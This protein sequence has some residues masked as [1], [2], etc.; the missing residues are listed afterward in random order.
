[1]RAG[2]WI[3]GSPANQAAPRN[4]GVG[5]NAKDVAPQTGASIEVQVTLDPLLADKLAPEQVLYIYAKALRGPP[6]PRQCLD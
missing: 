1:M 6:M 2:K 3:I 4:G 5:S